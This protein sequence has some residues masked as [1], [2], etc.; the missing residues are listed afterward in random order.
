MRKS[1]HAVSATIDFIC[2]TKISPQVRVTQAGMVSQP[3][4]WLHSH[5]PI[6]GYQNAAASYSQLRHNTNQNNYIQLLRSSAEKQV[7]PPQPWLQYSKIEDRWENT[8]KKERKYLKIMSQIPT[9]FFLSIS[10]K[11]SKNLLTYW[12]IARDLLI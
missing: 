9:N 12:H 6:I 11:Y 2:L 3:L 4:P 10:T 5:R 7:H 8:L 1:K